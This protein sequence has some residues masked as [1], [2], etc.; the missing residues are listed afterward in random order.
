M[1]VK[2]DNNEFRIHWRY[3]GKSVLC[4]IQGIDISNEKV[5]MLLSKAAHCGKKDSFCKETGR[6]VSLAKALLI[7]EADSSA[8][9]FS[10]EFRTKVWEAYRTL[11]KVPRWNVK[12][13]D[14]QH[15]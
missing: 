6:R 7:Y 13:K 1:I 3:E 5:F 12:V 10:R 15:A 14:K 11:T 9:L 2:D 4:I 8:K